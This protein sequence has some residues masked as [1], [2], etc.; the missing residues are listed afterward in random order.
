MALAA[1]DGVVSLLMPAKLLNAGYAAPLRRA[2]GANILA[3]EDW[4]D[5]PRRRQWFDADTFPLGVLAQKQSVRAREIAVFSCGE[6]FTLSRA[7]FASGGG[8]WALVPP[9]AA[10]ILRRL[11]NAHPTLETT[12]GRKPFM[13][14]KTGD[15][16]RYF[17]DVAEVRGR[18]AV[19]RDGLTIPLTAMSRCVRGR[20]VQRWSTRDS[21]WMLFP[22]P[23]GFPGR[24]EWLTR[25]A[26]SMGIE[27]GDL[28]LSFVRAEHTGIKVAWK[29]LS[30]GMA[31]VVLPD[32]VSVDGEPVPL[33]PN[34]TLYALD[35]QSLGE[36]YALAA[37]LNS[38]VAG[39]LLVAVAERAKDAH[40]RYF[41]RTVAALPLPDVRPHR[42]TL[43]R[44]SRRAHRGIDVSAEIDAVTATMYGVSEDELR[45]LREFLERRLHARSSSE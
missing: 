19:T 4:S 17:L 3:L 45:V 20:D 15:N 29:D 31:A 5:D 23:A 18:I 11:Q 6:S 2:Y 13:G 22:P 41:A 37:I 30:R 24:P 43:E 28:R 14:V 26:G 42:Q 36:A 9:D 21:H 34:Q 10:A 1:P 33:V 16:D 25:L 39:A 35:T 8:E 32:T 7:E 27:P 40:Y 38:T 12:L 44:L